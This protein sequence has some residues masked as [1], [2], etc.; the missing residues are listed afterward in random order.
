MA[1]IHNLKE[2]IAR[3]ASRDM[4]WLIELAAD[5]GERTITYPQ[6]H[7]EADAVARGLLRRG[8]ARGARIGLLAANSATYLMA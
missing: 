2:V 5:G 3:D 4:P 7:A 1:Q 8:L 6:M